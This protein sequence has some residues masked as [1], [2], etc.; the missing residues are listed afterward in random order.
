[1]NVTAVPTTTNSTSCFIF[2]LPSIRLDS[3]SPGFLVVVVVV[4]VEVVM[5]MVEVLG[6]GDLEPNNLLLPLPF[7]FIFRRCR[8]VKS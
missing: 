8:K 3:E 7:V 2:L 4:E 6:R 5:V 1:V